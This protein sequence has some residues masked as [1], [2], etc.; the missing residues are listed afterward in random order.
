[1]VLNDRFVWEPRGAPRRR[2][3]RPLVHSA[4]VGQPRVLE[5]RGWLGAASLAVWA[6][7]FGRLD[8]DDAMYFTLEVISK[9]RIEGEGPVT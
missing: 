4:L 7:T 1:V 6:A 3:G 5:M 9:L 8:N 2:S